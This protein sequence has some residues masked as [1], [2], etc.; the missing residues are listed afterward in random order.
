LIGVRAGGA[1]SV[2]AIR[3][4]TRQQE[5]VSTDPS[6]RWTLRRAVSHGAVMLERSSDR[7]VSP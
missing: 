5:E 7:L 3:A 4:E 1:A 6:L 2:A